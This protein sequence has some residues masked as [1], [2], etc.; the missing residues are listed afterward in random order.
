ML[1]KSL[2]QH[3]SD[4]EQQPSTSAANDEIPEQSSNHEQSTSTAQDDK[5]QTQDDGKNIN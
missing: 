3:D 1:G 5:N 2:Q 4:T